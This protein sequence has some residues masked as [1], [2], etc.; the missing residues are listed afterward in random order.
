MKMR[1]EDPSPS[2][3]VL[4]M[5]DFVEQAMDRADKILATHTENERPFQAI[6]G[7]KDG[8]DQILRSVALAPRVESRGLD[9]E[10]GA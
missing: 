6:P 2:R 1:T 3:V 4:E 7:P 9:P 5:L 10:V 8:A